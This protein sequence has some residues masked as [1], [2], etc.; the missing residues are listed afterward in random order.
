MDRGFNIGGALP[1]QAAGAASGAGAFAAG[2]PA[3]IASAYQGAYNSALGM[4]ESNYNNILAGYQQAI[5]AQTTA[6]QAIQSGYTG[7]YNTVLGN[8][9]N[10]YSGQAQQ[11]QN[12]AQQNLASSS[13]QLIDRGLGNTTIQTSV[14]QGVNNQLAQQQQLL[15]GQEA[16]T[17]AQYGSQL[18]LAGLAAQ[19]HG[20]DQTTGLA[21]SQL[22]FMNSADFQYPSGQM[23]AQLAQVAA[24]NAAM[25]NNPPYGGM[26]GMG[27]GGPGPQLGYVPGPTPGGIGSGTGDFG[28]G[29]FGSSMMGGY[30]A[31]GTYANNSGFTPTAA[32]SPYGPADYG[33]GGDW[34]PVGP[35]AGDT[36]IAGALTGVAQ[37][38][39][40]AP[41]YDYGGGGDF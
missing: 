7:L 41:V 24:Q 6:Q 17:M 8:A 32:A 20:L 38:A 34:A 29:S 30:G 18:G 22:N 28:G 4:N 19:Q 15:A 9:A 39:P 2:N 35:S 23:Y 5:G 3:G 10:I 27:L 21:L 16:G 31:G 13:Q 33:G 26:G 1:W 11:L 36:A 14:N 25:R 37:G 40:D 12:Q